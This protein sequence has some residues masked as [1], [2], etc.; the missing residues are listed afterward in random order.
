M[1]IREVFKFWRRYAFQK[2]AE[3]EGLE[4]DSDDEDYGDL[5][6]ESSGDY[7]RLR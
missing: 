1:S 7:Y 4:V 2:G 3:R 6:P 5:C